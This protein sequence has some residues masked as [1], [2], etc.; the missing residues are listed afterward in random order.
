MP[1]KPK[2]LDSWSVADSV[3]LNNSEESKTREL[4]AE[5]YHWFRQRFYNTA[6]A[7]G[8][9]SSQASSIKEARAAIHFPS[10]SMV[11]TRAGSYLFVSKTL[12]NGKHSQ[13]VYKF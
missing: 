5:I 13:S 7:I 6:S 3:D 11:L 12:A 10:R 1:I 9:V 2:K 4:T 8:T